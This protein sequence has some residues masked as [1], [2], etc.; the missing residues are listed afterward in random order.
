MARKKIRGKAGVK[1]KSPYT[2]EKRDSQLRTLVTHL[3]INEEVKVT[4][5]TAKSVV[6]LASKMITFAKKGDLHSRRLAAAVVRPMLVNENQTALQ[7]LFD[8]L[9]SNGSKGSHARQQF[10]RK[11]LDGISQNMQ[12]HKFKMISYLPL[13]NDK[14]ADLKGETYKEYP[15]VY[16]WC[17]KKITDI[18]SCIKR[19]KK[20]IKE[21][22][23]ED[24]EEKIILTYSA[25]PLHCIPAMMLR[26]K[27]GYKIV[28]ISSEISIHRRKEKRNASNY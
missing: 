13:V 24:D 21:W 15:I 20:L 27:Y 25:N 1:F 19:N 23:K 26:K 18:L 16:L 22:V 3:I 4:E 14:F 2:S 12:E 10:E 6:S 17:K 5:T 11:L 8:D 28:T 9:V 7:K